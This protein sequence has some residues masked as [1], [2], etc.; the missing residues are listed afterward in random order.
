MQIDM[1]FYATYAL[2]RAAG[3]PPDAARTVA[4]AA[5]FVDDAIEDTPVLLEHGALYVPVPSCHPLE[6]GQNLNAIDQWHV[7]LPYHF[8][9][10]NKGRTALE[11]LVCRRGDEKNQSANGIITFALEHAQSEFGPHLLGVMTHVLQDTYSHSGFMGISSDYNDVSVPSIDIGSITDPELLAEKS[12]L[13]NNL[14]QFVNAPGH[15]A[16]SCCPD[17]PYLRWSFDYEFGSDVCPRGPGEQHVE[18]DNQQEF[19]ASCKR[20]YDVFVRAAQAGVGGRKVSEPCKAY[21]E[22]E[23]EV[24]RILSLEA[25]RDR[26]GQAWNE[27][28]RHSTF[29][30]PEAEDNDLSYDELAWR[31]GR[32]EGRELHST[33]DAVLFMK[34]S[35]AYRCYVHSVLLPSLLPGV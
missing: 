21:T 35:H 4:H 20:L 10:G 9:P 25:K 24:R 3:I 16:V 27:A 29:C 6:S 11:R 32:H 2:A 22:I 18:R 14:V 31:A 28:L 17:Y 8:L 7:W 19:A 30:D 15:A 26:R 34:A 12:S 33:S 1:H 13:I 5:Q 23:P